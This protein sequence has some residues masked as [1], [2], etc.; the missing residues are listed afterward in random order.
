[1]LL[2]AQMRGFLLPEPMGGKYVLQEFIA[3]ELVY[4]EEALRHGIQGEVWL[5][6][7]VMRDGRVEDLHIWR[8]L[9]PLCDRE[10]L[11]LARL[12]QWQPGRVGDTP[13][14]SEHSIA[15]PF[16]PRTY[17]RWQRKRNVPD[18]VT[19]TLPACADL[20]IHRAQQVAIPPKPLL[21]VGQDLTQ[22]W[23]K[24]L[25]YPH[26]ALRRGIEGLL[27]VRFVVEPSGNISNLHALNDLGGGCIAETYRMLL[28]LPWQPAVVNNERVRAQV[29]LE[30]LFKLP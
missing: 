30:I 9:H 25:K 13:V 28:A 14:D 15:I 10:A 29:D 26:E 7:N 22:W 17:T 12:I 8:G 19:A 18:S 5:K 20:R 24:Q 1:V 3:R 16:S 6:F 27:H 23:R 11:R 21:P 4:P 2:V